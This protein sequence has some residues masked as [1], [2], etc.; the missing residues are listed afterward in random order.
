M[1][2]YQCKCGEVTVTSS[3]G[4]ANGCRVRLELRARAS[5]RSCQRGG[6]RGRRVRE[7]RPW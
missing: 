1:L 2:Y 5:G 4:A 3:M 6:S 7:R